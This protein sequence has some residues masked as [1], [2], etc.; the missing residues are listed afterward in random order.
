MSTNPSCDPIGEG[1]LS[2]LRQTARQLPVENPDL[3]RRFKLGDE[4]AVADLYDR[5]S[6]LVYSVAY[7]ILRDPGTSEDVLQD[8][9][10]QLWR[11]PDAFDPSKGTLGAWLTVVSRRR[12]IDRLRKR[13]AETDVADLVVSVDATQLD[14]A[15]LNQ[16]THKVGALLKDMPQKLRVAF[17]LAYMHGLTHCEISERLGSPLGTTKSRIRQALDFIRK[18]LNGNRENTNGDGHV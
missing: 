4:Q 7:Q 6:R 17:E 2:E 9:F 8:V 10:L 15:A 13:K 16:F 5:Y 14:D 12:A 11:V 3:W 1:D 18:K